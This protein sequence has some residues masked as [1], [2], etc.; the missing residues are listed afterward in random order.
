MSR[1][2]WKRVQSQTRESSSENVKAR[3]R[4][5]TS[6]LCETMI[7]KNKQRKREESDFMGETNVGD[8]DIESFFEAFA[9]KMEKEDFSDDE[10][11][12]PDTD[13]SSEESSDDNDDEGAANQNERQRF[14]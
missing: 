13:S 3:A 10:P 8:M 9:D 1:P 7:K 12:E 14:K 2:D 6:E 5:K 4:H 11:E